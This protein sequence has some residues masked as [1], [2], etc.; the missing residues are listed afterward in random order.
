MNK[1]NVR[2]LSEYII[3]ISNSLS[4]D[5][6]RS[7]VKSIEKKGNFAN[8]LIESDINKL[9]EIVKNNFD[10]YFEKVMPAVSLLEEDSDGFNLELDTLRLDEPGAELFN[11][12]GKGKS[13]RFLAFVFIVSENNSGSI[14]DFPSQKVINNCDLGD[15]YI[16]PPY[17]THRFSINNNKNNNFRSILVFARL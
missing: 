15:L 14:I 3:K 2:S 4:V 6:C 8:N 1:V 11:L 13:H 9:S 16:I 7:L 10:M 5:T 12:G 17:F